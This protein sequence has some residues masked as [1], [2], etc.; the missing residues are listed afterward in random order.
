[1]TQRLLAVA[2]QQPLQ[3]KVVDVN[4]LILRMKELLGRTLPRAIEIEAVLNPGLWRVLVDESQLEAAVLNLSL[5]ARDAMPNGGMLR[6]ESANVYFEQGWA[7]R[8]HDM[9]PGSYVV[10]TV[11]DTGIGMTR[12]VALRALEPFFTTK[13]GGKSSGL[14]L[15]M[16]YGF[17]K[18]S[19]GEIEIDST[20][21]KGTSVRLLLP[22]VDLGDPPTF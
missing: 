17:I 19:G 3:P 6:L 11:T 20:P 21:G 8:Q 5:N 15:S 1:M 22:K 13:E 14:G 9:P 12:D 18:Q 16:I 10:V 7:D 2:R 4:Q